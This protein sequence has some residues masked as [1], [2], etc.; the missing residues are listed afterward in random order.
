MKPRSRWK[1]PLIWL[2][3]GLLLVWLAPPAGGNGP[4][5]LLTPAATPSPVQVCL[6]D[7]TA[8]YAGTRD[9]YLDR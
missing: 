1:W 5:S 6:Q 4:A 7:G 8:G 2:A 3:G 9:T